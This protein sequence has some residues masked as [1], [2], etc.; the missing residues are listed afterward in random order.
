MS[1]EVKEVKHRNCIIR[2]TPTEQF[3]NMVTVV[4]TP[5][6]RKTFL[7]SRYINIHKC[8]AHIELVESE[9]LINSKEKYVKQTLKEVVIVEE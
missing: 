1:I 5:N 3:P 6:L 2:D 8:V 4:K 9:R 7:D